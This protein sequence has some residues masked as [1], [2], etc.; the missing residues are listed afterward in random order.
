MSHTEGRTARRT[1]RGTGKA[2]G[3]ETLEH[4]VLLS[5][6]GGGD[7]DRFRI[8]IN[9]T[10]ATADFNND[11]KL[12]TVALTTL[13][14][15]KKL[16]VSAVTTELGQGNGVFVAKDIEQ[17]QGTPKAIVAGDFNGDGNQ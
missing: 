10:I 12:D 17:V 2:G 4:R 8:G 11:K 1:G 15:G 3:V 14:V 16:R 7:D 5:G 9:N 6:G 13:S